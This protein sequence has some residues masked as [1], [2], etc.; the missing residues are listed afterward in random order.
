MRF[1]EVDQKNDQYRIGIHMGHRWGLPGIQCPVCGSAWSTAGLAF[2]CV[3]L[4]GHP[5][6]AKLATPRLEKDFDEFIRLRES[7]RPLV[8]AGMELI[9]GT[10]FGPAIGPA[11][12]S[13]FGV[14]T[15]GFPWMMLARP[16]GVTAMQ[17]EGVRGLIAGPTAFTWRRDPQHVLE[18]QIEPHGHVHPDCLPPDL[19][20][21][22]KCGWSSA[23]VPKPLVLDLASLPIDRDI[24]RLADFHT[25]IVV[26]ERFVE[27]CT[28]LGIEDLAFTELAGR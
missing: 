8:S 23:P 14:L 6:A 13:H 25:V 15:M 24:F 28:R 21:C 10:D 4:S 7:V 5:D 2:P 12:G 22:G 20:R 19:K 16:E 26:T 27:A 11:E 9:A 17:A 18:L 1:Y 3:D